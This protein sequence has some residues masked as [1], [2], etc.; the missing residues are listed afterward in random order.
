[1]TNRGFTLVELMVVVAITAL[2]GAGLRVV[3]RGSRGEKAPGAAR[4][5][6]ALVREAQHAATTLQQPTRVRLASATL[7]FTEQRNPVTTTQW[8]A[9]SGRTS[10]PGGVELCAVDAM[11]ALSNASPTCPLPGATSICFDVSGRVSVS[12][13]GSCPR[14]LPTGATLYLHTVDGGHKYKVPIFSL[15]GTARLVDTW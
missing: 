13:D 2:T 3:S 15:T 6:L 1:M 10:M 14:V 12:A 7:A 11:A 9:L 8:D 5:L 4:N